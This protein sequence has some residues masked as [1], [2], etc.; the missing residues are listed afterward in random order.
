MPKFAANPSLMK[1]DNGIDSKRLE[2][3]YSL[4]SVG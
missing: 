2:L 4:V 3:L 1:D